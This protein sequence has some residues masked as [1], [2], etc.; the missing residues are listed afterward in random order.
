[1]LHAHITQRMNSLHDFYLGLN[2]KR[3][4]RPRANLMW[5]YVLWNTLFHLLTFT[6]WSSSLKLSVSGLDINRRGGG[7]TT[8]YKK[9]FRFG[10]TSTR[11]KSKVKVTVAVVLP[12]SI[13]KTKKY[14]KQIKTAAESLTDLTFEKNGFELSPYLEMVQPIPTPTEVLGKICD[15]FLKNN[16]AAILYLNDNENYGRYSV[17]SQYFIQLAQYVQLPIISWNADNSAFEQG[18]GESLQ[19]QLAPTIKHQARAILTLLERYGW[20]TFSIVTSEIAGH[21]NFEQ[22]DCYTI[23][24]LEQF[25]CSPAFFT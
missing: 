11:N 6:L 8:T 1:M 15:Q 9:P 16:T 4:K 23:C 21:R 7:I 22:V 20:H 13:F 14:L 2:G 24:F 25:I 19:L 12:H 18:T 5:H 10:D 17:A 3:K